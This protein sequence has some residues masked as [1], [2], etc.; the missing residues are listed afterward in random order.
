MG[1][2]PKSAK[3]D[4]NQKNLEF[5]L[6]VKSLYESVGHPREKPVPDQAIG[7]PFP[8]VPVY[9]TDNQK[10]GAP[11]KLQTAQYPDPHSRFPTHPYSRLVYQVE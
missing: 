5:K 3:I 10:R 8:I 7:I 4:K 1:K 2:I 6:I 9:I 11:E